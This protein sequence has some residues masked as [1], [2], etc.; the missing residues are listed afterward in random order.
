LITLVA[1]VAVIA[2]LFLYWNFRRERIL[3]RNLEDLAGQTQPVDFA[4]FSNLLD[5]SQE[6]F[7]K[8]RLSSS[9]YRRI[10][11][12]RLLATLEY[13]KRLAHNAQVLMRLGE[14]ARSSSDPQVAT[15]AQAL[16]NNAL[17]MRLLAMS[18]IVK[19]YGELWVPQFSTQ[20]E[21]VADRYRQLTDAAG[22]LARLQQPAFAGRVAALL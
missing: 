20:M 14:A 6:Q 11:R 16:V 1:V 18:A 4:A 13:V 17:R 2:I 7:L 9:D 21:P 10:R 5:A 12:A 15:A 19:L 8:Q 22:L 3:V